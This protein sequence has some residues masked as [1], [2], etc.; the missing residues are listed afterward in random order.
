[1]SEKPTSRRRFIVAALTFST[2]SALVPGQSWLRS[3]AAWAESVDPAET[4]AMARMARLLFPHDGMPDRIYAD[5]ISKV[6]DNFAGDS[7]TENLLT[8]AVQAL[9]AQGGSPWFD[10]P[11]ENQVAAIMAVQDQPFFA[12]IL[13]SV[14]GAFYYEPSVW[15]YLDYPGSSKQHGGYKDRGFDDIDWLP[16]DK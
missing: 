2:V 16:G 14:R 13:A 12:S 3:S 10:L 4:D 8:T 6:F 9:D 7:A 1:M 15:R 11:E 5:V